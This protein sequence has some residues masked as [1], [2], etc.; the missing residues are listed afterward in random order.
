MTH[1][2]KDIFE[3]LCDP[4]RQEADSTIAA[5]TAA[6]GMLPSKSEFGKI[7]DV[8][9]KELR[10][11]VMALVDAY[12]EANPAPS[13]SV[14]AESKE[15]VEIVLESELARINEITRSSYA[16]LANSSALHGE[17]ATKME[18][19]RRAVLKAAIKEI[20]AWFAL[21]Q[22]ALG[23]NMRNLENS[24]N[25][26]PMPVIPGYVLIEKIGRGGSGEV[27]KASFRD[28]AAGKNEIAIKVISTIF[29]E[30]LRSANTRFLRETDAISKLRHRAIVEFVNA[31][32][33][34]EATPKPYISMGLV[35]GAPLSKCAGTMSF[36]ERVAAMVSVLDALV[37]AHAQGV[38]HRDVKPG[39]IVIRSS[40]SQAILVDFGLAYVFEGMS[41]E[42]LTKYLVG[43]MGYIPPEVQA[44][45]LLRTPQHDVFSCGVTLFEILAGQRPVTTNPKL[46]S[47]ISTELAGLDSIIKK[48]LESP[49]R[50]YKSV[51]ELYHALDLWHK[52]QLSA[53]SVRTSP[54]LIGLKEKLL[55]QKTQYETEQQNIKNREVFINNQIQE[56]HVK[57]TAI[58]E[59]AFN[60]VLAEVQSVYPDY[61]YEKINP[62]EDMF[63]GTTDVVAYFGIN[64]PTVQ[65]K[66]LLGI[67]WERNQIQT[68]GSP[69]RYMAS[70]HEAPGETPEFIPPY[71]FLYTVGPSQSP[72]IQRKGLIACGIQRMVFDDLA[73]NVRLYRDNMVSE[74]GKLLHAGVIATFDELKDYITWVLAET[75]K[76]GG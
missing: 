68:T 20:E 39:N 2:I 57:V 61:K 12:K 32:F 5:L 14:V 44:N 43:S 35:E 51:Q 16:I 60:E 74:D 58:A 27:Y 33:T 11:V 56:H 3:K 41:T 19:S 7:Y 10:L 70:L 17:L 38:F 59:E 40:D 21:H 30:D 9:E 23:P 36:M 53:K 34:E 62:A 24:R 45:P 54:R 71:W 69:L 75:I 42:T 22:A 6:A 48:A 8:R 13:Q 15:Q 67:T 37:Y 52:R 31:G 46:L 26:E 1:L 76:R 49:E 65:R 64:Y 25:T 63:V 18:A 4:I 66:F 47:A 73:P 50:R 28:K 29:D 72:Q 55:E